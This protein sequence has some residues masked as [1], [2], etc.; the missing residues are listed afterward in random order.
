MTKKDFE[1]IAYIFN[2]NREDIINNMQGDRLFK[3]YLE[4]NDNTAELFSC[5]LALRYE[6]F[7]KNR[8]LRACGIEIE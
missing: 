7:D 3:I 6:R 1:L 8:F 4:D 5:E 2:S